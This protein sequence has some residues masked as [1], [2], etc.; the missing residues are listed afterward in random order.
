MNTILKSQILEKIS[1]KSD[2]IGPLAYLV[3][4]MSGQ[5]EFIVKV[6]DGKNP[7]I[8]FAVNCSSTN[9]QNSI[10]IDVSDPKTNQ[11]PILLNSE[12][13][14]ILFF[15]SSEFVSWKIEILKVSAKNELE[16]DSLKLGQ[17]DLM[18][19]NFI[20]PGKYSIQSSTNQTSEIEVFHPEE[21][22]KRQV[23]ELLTNRFSVADFKL[24]QKKILNPNQG[25]VFEFS[26]EMSSLSINMLEEKTAKIP[27]EEKVRNELKK[28]VLLQKNKQTRFQKKF[29][30]SGKII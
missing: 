26:K 19:V 2:Q 5:G 30:W 10:N 18:A 15:H 9:K 24:K 12:N 3:H 29:K 22:T 23:S 8:E 13:G 20:K 7:K 11:N 17:G 21:I 27:F 25:M 1:F 28:Q 16:F 6:S 4:K 14:Y